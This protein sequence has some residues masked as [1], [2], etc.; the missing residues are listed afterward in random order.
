[1]SVFIF[2]PAGSLPGAGIPLQQVIEFEWPK[3]PVI[4]WEHSNIHLLISLFTGILCT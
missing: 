4:S 2:M 1:M 3:H